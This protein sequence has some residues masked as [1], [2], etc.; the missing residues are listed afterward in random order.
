MVLA[1]VFMLTALIRPQILSGFYRIWMRGAIAVGWF[2][3]KVILVLLY[4]LMFGPLT[5]VIKIFGGDLLREKIDNSA[6]TF[7]NRVEEKTV[8]LERYQKQF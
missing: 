8:T 1:L 3:T 6:H 2:N 4:Y 7:W 5:I